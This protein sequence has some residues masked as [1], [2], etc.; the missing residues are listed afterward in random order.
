[1]SLTTLAALTCGN[2]TGIAMTKLLQDKVIL[3]TGAATGIGQAAAQLAASEG[4]Q[5]ILADIDAA[6]C[7][8]TAQAIRLQDGLAHSEQLDVTD[9]AAFQ[10]CVQ[11]IVAK[12]GWLDGAVNNAGIPGANALIADY[13]DETLQR[14][15]DVNVKGVWNGL[16]A[17][18][19]A[20]LDRG[21]GAIVNVA[22]IGGIV[23]KDGQSAYIASK[24]A[25]I[26]LTKTAALEYGGAGVR[27]NA[28][29]PGI[30]RTAMIEQIIANDRAS[31]QAWDSLQPIGRMGL[32]EE[33]AEAIVWLLSDRSS[34]LHGHSLVADGAYTVG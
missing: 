3:I 30:I 6:A 4:A 22:S 5:V 7:E 12:Y 26:G 28:V 17:Q 14:V 10:A 11:R 31:A 24:H 23:G 18:I 19:V 8:A 15:L 27:I 25:V 1:M 2:E 13:P 21:V 33:V 34:L 16:K 32:P 29:C 9:A 20:M